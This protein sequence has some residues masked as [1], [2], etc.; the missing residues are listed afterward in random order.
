MI[1][2]ESFRMLSAKEEEDFF[3]ASLSTFNPKNF[4]TY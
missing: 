2:L 4:C 3:N 1:F